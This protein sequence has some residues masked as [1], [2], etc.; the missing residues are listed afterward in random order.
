MQ[1]KGRPM[2][3]SIVR[4]IQM[5]CDEFSFASK[6]NLFQTYHV[7]IILNNINKNKKKKELRINCVQ[8]K[9]NP[10]HVIIFSEYINCFNIF[11]DL[12][13]IFFFSS[14]LLK[15]KTKQKKNKNKN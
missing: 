3:N 14:H 15:I 9:A 12:F 6:K 5:C 10:N 13:T 2:L 11:L 8:I 1:E 4:G 7:N